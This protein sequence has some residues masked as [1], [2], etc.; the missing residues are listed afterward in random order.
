MDSI[1]QNVILGS[2]PFFL[3]ISY[4]PV[5]KFPLPKTVCWVEVI[6]RL[7][8]TKIHAVW[9]CKKKHPA[10]YYVDKGEETWKRKIAF[11]Q[12]W[13]KGTELGVKG[14]KLESLV[15]LGFFKLLALLPLVTYRYRE[16]V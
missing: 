3:V 8:N 5:P 4:F 13:G 11:S 2:L 7:K 9:V 6:D 15:N 16:D 10:L 12:R 1:L 14:L